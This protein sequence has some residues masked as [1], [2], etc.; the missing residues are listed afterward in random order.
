MGKLSAT[1]A[2]IGSLAAA[3]QSEE[4]DA[5]FIGTA[6][7]T[8]DHVAHA[9][10]V[11]MKDAGVPRK[12]IWQKTGVDLDNVD[13]LPRMEVDDSAATFDTPGYL[14]F[15]GRSL[16]RMGYKVAHPA[17]PEWASTAAKEE[18]EHRLKNTL[19]KDALDHPELYDAYPTNT[20]GQGLP[21]AKLKTGVMDDT[22]SGSYNPRTDQITVSA[23]RIGDM[24]DPRS[25]PLHE[26]Q[27]AIQ[28]REGFAKGGSPDA[29]YAEQVKNSNRLNFLSDEQGK[30]AR[31]MDEITVSYGQPK[32]GFEDEYA[33]IKS[34]YDAIMDEKMSMVNIQQKD[35]R[36]AYRALAG[37]AEA[38]NVQTR[39]DMDWK[40][41][42][43][44]P[45]YETLDVPESD[46]IVRMGGGGASMM[47]EGDFFN[48]IVPGRYGD[49]SLEIIKN[50]SSQDYQRLTKEV[51]DEYPGTPREALSPTT[52]HTIDE[53]GNRYIWRSDKGAHFQ[54]EPQISQRVGRGVDQNNFELE[55]ARKE[56]GFAN[57]EALAYTA[58][59]TGAVGAFM[60][61]R[62][63][64]KTFWQERKQDLKDLAGKYVEN[65]P[66]A[67]AAAGVLSQLDWSDLEAPTTG[68]YGLAA[69]AANLDQGLGPALEQ[70]ARV[71]QQPVEQTAQ[72]FGDYVY[73]NTG[74]PGLATTALTA[75]N[76]WGPI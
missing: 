42:R 7:K 47:S 52:R 25:T 6:A 75:A 33:A 27:H 28:Q 64:K 59:L 62:A 76:V 61:S 3:G 11:K 10:A 50:P 41:R 55:M 70:G 17:T 60:E 13:G 2:G 38:R 34:E 39:L 63:Q 66:F 73:D 35:P 26:T 49:E 23:G 16:D 9:L 12:E 72:Q 1:L 54:I 4:A 19:L 30:I 57:P 69:T 40:Q 68:I 56:R 22:L 51:M 74:S 18:A 37:E 44:V 8:F 36:D 65:N 29:I 53:D 20:F 31:R 15:Y 32:A 14:D 67:V 5:S 45:P 48:V 24:K 46:Q 71:A 43:E 58:A 21:N